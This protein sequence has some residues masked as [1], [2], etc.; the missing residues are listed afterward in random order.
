MAKI[1]AK[2]V[3]VDEIKGK[4]DKAQSVVLVNSRGL[5]VSQDTELRRAMREA[6]VDFKVYKNTMINFAIKGTPYEPLSEHLEGP[7]TV[8]FSYDDATSAARTI[9][10]FIDDFGP[11]EYKG[12]VI[13][14]T[15]YGAEDL[16]KVG[17]IPSREVLLS[18]L[19]GSLQSPMSAFARVIKQAAEKMAE[20]PAE[21]P[22]EAAAETAAEAP[23]E[24]AAE[25]PA[26]AEAAEAPA[27]ADNAAAEAPAEQAAEAP[28]A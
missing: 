10:K 25:A 5:T 20:E 3:V 27:S 12:G 28:Q 11:L 17:K 14:G 16:I 24:A 22:A 6:G 7:T 21:A 1:E 9:D 2:Q 18:K 26:Q 23:A 8:A 19:L 4:L 13:E 15:Y